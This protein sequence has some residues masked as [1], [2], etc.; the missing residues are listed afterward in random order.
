MK[1]ENL[2]VQ[3]LKEYE[4]G[5]FELA[6]K[7]FE[8]G[9]NAGNVEAMQMLALLYAG[10]DGV[11]RDF[12]KSIYWDKRAIELGSIV[13]LSNLAITYRMRGDIREAKSWFEKAVKTGDGDAAL[14]LA[15]L[16][17]VTDKE[18]ETIKNLLQQVVDSQNVTEASVE[19][20]KTFLKE[21]RV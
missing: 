7:K 14:D 21:L 16:Y 3:A 8:K 15:K 19:Q 11:E 2:Y 20:A 17:M 12:E 13:S 6:A 1:L 4:L 9:A 18:K 5:K 10:G